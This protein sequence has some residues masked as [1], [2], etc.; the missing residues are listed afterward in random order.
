MDVSAIL[1][2]A[3]SKPVSPER[4][5]GCCRVFVAGF[6]KSLAKKVAAAANKVGLSY[7]AETYYGDRCAIYVAYDNMVGLGLARASAIVAAF[8]SAGVSCY[9]SECGD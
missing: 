4:P 2:S 3:M 8:Q 6:D 1:Q 9:R 7:Q 5:Q